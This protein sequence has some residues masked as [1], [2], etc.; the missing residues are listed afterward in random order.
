M[1]Y[2]ILTATGWPGWRLLRPVMPFGVGAVCIWLILHQIDPAQL[3]DI[4]A[5]LAEVSAWRWALAGL[6]TA[7]SFWALGRYD[8]VFHRFLATGLP[9][10]AAV[11]SGASAI[12]VAQVLGF[13]IVTGALVRWRVLPGLSAAQA[14]KIAVAVALSFVVCLAGLVGTAGLIWSGGLVPGWLCIGLIFVCVVMVCVT[15]AQPRL[16]LAGHSL[17]LPS[18]PACA[19]LAWLSAIDTAAAA[20]A[21]FVLM[22]S[23]VGLD[24]TQ[25]YVVYL[26]ALTAALLSGTPGGVGPFELTVIACLPALPEPDVLAA[27][28]AFRLVYY[29]LPAVVALPFLAFPQR[30]AYAA[31]W[32]KTQGLSESDISISRRAELG[33]CRQNNAQRLQIGDT[34]LAVI[35]TPQSCTM[36]FDPVGPVHA[37]QFTRLSVHATAQDRWPLAYKSSAR[38]A[39]M[40]RRAGWQAIHI[41]D[42]AVICAHSY[43]TEG[44]AF[45]QLRRKLRQAQK[46][47]VTVERATYLPLAALTRIDAEWQNVNGGARGVSMGQYSHSYLRAQQ[48]FIARQG[49]DIIGFIS[50]HTGVHETCLDLMRTT[51]TAPNGTMHLLVHTAVVAA[52]TDGVARV[53]LAA[54]PRVP[55]QLPELCQRLLRRAHPAGLHQFKASFAPRYEPLYA[56]APTRRALIFGL[57]DMAMVIHAP[58]VN[59]PHHVHEEKPFAQAPQT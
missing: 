50:L 26:L 29:A 23:G 34:A 31:I 25:V 33:V 45:R 55:H 44:P 42:E 30:R 24:W 15:L 5:A 17:P 7:V 16:R 40:A 47:G 57:L 37:E 38:V 53:S 6:A 28:L 11:I 13:G 10:R 8:V 59:T 48:V 58:Q 49:T 36:L 51:Q 43:S 35:D 12:A 32:A 2:K 4:P 1:K 41:A 39:V 54:L 19:R 52:R 56:M 27:I 46:A 9:E 3:R 22:P 14:S 20:T 18:L 21:L